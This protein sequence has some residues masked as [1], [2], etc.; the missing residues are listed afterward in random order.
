MWGL[1]LLSL[2]TLNITC[3]HSEKNDMIVNICKYL[4]F[5]FYFTSLLSGHSSS[6]EGLNLFGVWKMWP[7]KSM[8]KKVWPPPK[9][10]A[11]EVSSP[12]PKF[13]VPFSNIIKSQTHLICIICPF[14]AI[15]FKNGEEGGMKVIFCIGG[16][17]KYHFVV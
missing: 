12:P 3:A 10:N 13:E 17:Q 15:P 14:R 2:L 7:L 8:R 11:K 1:L 4:E 6:N 5:C 9:I 16:S